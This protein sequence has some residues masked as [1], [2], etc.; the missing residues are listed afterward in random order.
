MVTLDPPYPLGIFLF[1]PIIRKFRHKFE[2]LYYLD[3]VQNNNKLILGVKHKP[4]SILSCVDL[5]TNGNCYSKISDFQ[6]HMA[7]GNITVP[8]AHGE[9]PEKFGGKG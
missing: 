8:V 2:N 5:Y 9:K 6:L 3:T 7:S 1:P 4:E